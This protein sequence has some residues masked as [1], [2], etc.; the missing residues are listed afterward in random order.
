METQKDSQKDLHLTQQDFEFNVKEL[1]ITNTIKGDFTPIQRIILTADGN[2]QRILSAYF[3]T[4]IKVEIIK[5]N[6][7]DQE[8]H[9]SVLIYTGTLLICTASSVVTTS[10]NEIISMLPTHGL[11]QIFKKL[12]INWSL[13][14]WTFIKMTLVFA[15]S[16]C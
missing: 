8:Y 7:I 9:R 3:N 1:E 14:S 15:E 13:S 12:N 16:I 6:I 2:C 10:D 5:N 4:K 11:G